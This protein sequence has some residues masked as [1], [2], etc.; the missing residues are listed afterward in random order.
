MESIINKGDDELNFTKID[1]F[2]AIFMIGYIFFYTIVCRYIV[3]DLE[4]W[5]KFRKYF[6][7]RLFANFLFEIPQ[8]LLL[9]LPIFI[10]LRYRK[11]SLKSI[12]FNKNKILKQ[13]IIGIILYIPLYLLSLRLN[14]KSGIN[15]N[16][17]SI[18]IWTFLFMLTDIALVEEIVY[19]GFIQQRLNGLIRNKYINLLVAAFIFGS[20]PI[21]FLIAQSNLTF[22]QIIRLVIPKM[23]MH[24]Y[25]VGIY[26]AGNNSVLSSTIAHGLNNF[27]ASL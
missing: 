4:L 11:Q 18:S 2:L 8:S 5:D 3:Y 13:I 1:G 24:I 19:R 26:K 6:N 23:F 22:V 20:L 17:N 27:I 12:G 25:F 14:G 15:I 10:I 7:N 16:L 9:L 21:P